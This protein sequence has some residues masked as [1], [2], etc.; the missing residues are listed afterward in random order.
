MSREDEGRSRSNHPADDPSNMGAEP[1]PVM[2]ASALSGVRDI[3]RRPGP[4]KGDMTIGIWET[5]MSKRLGFVMSG[6][7]SR[8]GRHIEDGYQYVGGFPADRWRLATV[9]LSYKTLSYGIQTFPERWRALKKEIDRPLHYVSIGPG[10]GE[11]DND[12]LKHLQHLAKQAGDTPVVYVPVDISADLLKLSFENSLKDIDDEVVDVVPIELDITHKAAIKFLNTLRTAF[13]GELPV[14]VSLLGNTLANF[15][16]D[17]KML[18]HISKA[19]GTPDDR[20]LLE[21]ATTPDATPEMAEVAEEEYDGS[22]SFRDFVMAGLFQ[23]TD[24][25]PSS[26]EVVYEATAQPGRLLEVNALFAPET[27]R[28]VH[29][30]DGD[31]FKLKPNE[32]ISLYKS[33]K[34]T[35]SGLTTLL[36]GFGN[37]EQAHTSYE[38]DSGFG[39]VTTLLAKE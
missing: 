19:L 18:K 8:R 14:L 24:C 4:Q 12:I 7:K 2:F 35:E 29:L 31:N 28:I 17:E 5:K 23:Y 6:L 36:G 30:T 13:P 32:K 25:P 22:K 33:R 39:V 27:E 21:L 1:D 3:L 16:D 9:D 37:V 20:L 10:T 11:K 34:Y 38:D 26:G 15:A